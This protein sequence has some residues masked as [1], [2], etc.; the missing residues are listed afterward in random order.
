[1]LSPKPFSYANT[2]H[3]LHDSYLRKPILTPEQHL[4]RD[5]YLLFSVTPQTPQSLNCKYFSSLRRGLEKI[6]I[7][8]AGKPGVSEKMD[9]S[10]IC[11]ETWKYVSVKKCPYKNIQTIIISNYMYY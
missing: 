10:H 6:D 9:F 8:S 5:I 11:E 2:F 3:L 1:M 4:H 7:F